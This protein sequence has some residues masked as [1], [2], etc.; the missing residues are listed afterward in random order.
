[1]N[2]HISKHAILFN[3]KKKWAVKSKCMVLSERNK[4]EKATYCMIPLIWQWGKDKTM[5]TG[6]SPVVAKSEGREE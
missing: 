6:E 1:M 5:E 3:T 4:S 2:V